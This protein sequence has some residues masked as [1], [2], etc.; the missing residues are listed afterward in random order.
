MTRAL[1]LLALVAAKSVVSV[2]CSF[3]NSDSVSTVRL[4]RSSVF[5][6]SEREHWRITEAMEVSRRLVS[7][8]SASTTPWRDHELGSLTV[9]ARR[10]GLR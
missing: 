7:A 9:N 2:L 10:I 3:S 4:A 5:G 1:L 8:L 6:G